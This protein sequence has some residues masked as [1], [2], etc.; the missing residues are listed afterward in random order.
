MK[1]GKKRKLSKFGEEFSRVRKK[2]KISLNEASRMLGY[3]PSYLSAIEHGDRAI[4]DDLLN[5][6]KKELNPDFYEEISLAH[7]AFDCSYLPKITIQDI[8]KIVQNLINNLNL[9]EDQI[10]N[11]NNRF[12]ELIKQLYKK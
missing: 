7:A 1:N 10:I 11:A 8:S 5:K 6:I 2:R 4:P 3:S 12:D 9:D